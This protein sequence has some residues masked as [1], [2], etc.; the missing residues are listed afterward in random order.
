ML[1]FPFMPLSRPIP[2]QIHSSSWNRRRHWQI[3]TRPKFGEDHLITTGNISV[4]SVRV[5]CDGVLAK[6]MFTIRPLQGLV[7]SEGN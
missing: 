1:F 5:G 2:H 7:P 4:K 3:Y 6:S